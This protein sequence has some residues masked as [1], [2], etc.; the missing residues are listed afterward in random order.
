MVIFMGMQLVTN[1]YFLVYS[2]TNHVSLL[3]TGLLSLMD[4][5]ESTSYSEMF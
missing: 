2:V 3:L 1:L 4:N 5:S